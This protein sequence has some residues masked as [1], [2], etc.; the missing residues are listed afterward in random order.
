MSMLPK[1]TAV[2]GTSNCELAGFEV[3]FQRRFHYCQVD[4]ALVQSMRK[5]A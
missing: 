1:Q 5:A 2:V 3:R 4:L